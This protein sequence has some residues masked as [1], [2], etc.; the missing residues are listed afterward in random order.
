MAFGRNRYR[1]GRNRHIGWLSL[2]NRS[3][4]VS[5]AGSRRGVV[6]RSSAHRLQVLIG[7]VNGILSRC[8]G[9]RPAVTLGTLFLSGVAAS[10]GF[11]CHD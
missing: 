10:A 7:A 6:L 11:R 8:S 5:Q 3:P 4:G 2:W 1:D 9:C